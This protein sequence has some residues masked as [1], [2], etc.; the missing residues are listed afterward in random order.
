MEV[1]F[2]FLKEME[3][4]DVGQLIVKYLFYLFCLRGDYR[5]LKYL[6]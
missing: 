5:Y 4:I 2:Y 1:N 6:N 3:Q